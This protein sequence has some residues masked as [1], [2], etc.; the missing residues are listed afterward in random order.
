MHNKEEFPGENSRWT[1]LLSRLTTAALKLEANCNALQ[2]RAHKAETQN[3]L[4][5]EKIV[6]ER[7]RAIVRFDGRTVDI[8]DDMM[9][10]AHQ[11]LQDEIPEVEW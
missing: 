5:K 4:L 3:K 8:P 6:E 11:Q 9:Q 2:S 7:A 10:H 1:D